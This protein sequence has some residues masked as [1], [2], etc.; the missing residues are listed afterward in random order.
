MFKELRPGSPT[1]ISSYRLSFFEKLIICRGLKFSL[2]QKV[3]PIDVQ[4]SFEKLYWK[5][6]DKL[7]D[8]NLKE[9]AASTLRSIALNYIQRKSPNPPKA[10]VKALNRLKERDDIVITRPD[11]G[12][13]TV[14]MDKEE[15][16]RLLRQA[17]IADTSKFTAIDPDR[18]KTRGRPP[19]HFHPLLQK[20]KEL[21]AVLHQ[22]LPEKLAESLSP[23]GSRLAHLYGLPKT[24]KPTLS[25]RP[26]LSASGTYNYKLAKWLEEKLKPLSVNQYTIDDALGFSKEIR[27]HPVLEDDILVSYD[28]T[29]LFTNV[30][31][32]ETINIL[33][34]KAFADDWFNSTYDLNLQKDQL[35]QLLRMASTDQLFQF[36]GQLY[37]QC[38]GV[39][40]GSPLGPL[41]ANVFMC[42][43]EE[44]LADNDL[45]P[46]FYKRY[47]DDTLAIMP[48]LDAAEN[49]LDVLN[50]LHPSI[51]FTME[52]SKNDSIPFIGTLITKNGN[53]LESQVYRKPTNTGLLL[54]FQSHTDLR[55]KKCLIKTM[56]HRAKELSSTHQ[57]FVDECRHLKSMFHHL[58]YPRSLVNCIIDRCDYSC[59]L[60]AKTK[61]DEILRV[62]IPFKDQVSANM[63]KRQ[64]RDLSSKIGIDVQPIYTS[65]KLEQDLKLKEIKP[66]IV[67]QHSVV[68][69]FKC[70]LCDSNYVGYTTRHLFQ[71]IADHRYSAI[72]RHLRDA[73]G[74]IDLLN[75]SQ[76]RMLKKCSTKWDCLV[77]EMLYIRT[78]R[79]NLNTQSD[80]IRAKLFV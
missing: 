9:L 30:P 7:S 13:G 16:L 42:H 19:K 65:K 11:K 47:V 37:E 50:G 56:V 73:H 18:P 3:S 76:F 71:R 80:S 39:A 8:P 53:T 29:S 36:D 35:T 72:G 66:R 62:S 77:Y 48:G 5:I 57:A 32:Q 78:I 28:V 1:N 64:M 55:Y 59:T 2:P 67:N 69:C 31:V 52:L 51:H 24:H 41:L 21:K 58:S 12:S 27:K 4:A 63:V 25:M 38:E 54:H 68:Y 34:E 74:N 43:L 14:V 23:K 44:R 6:D 46:S 70:D 61:S 15:Y 49:F 79:P 17:S 20:E 75:E 10:L 26:I 45:I 33:V 40:M 22:V 60:D